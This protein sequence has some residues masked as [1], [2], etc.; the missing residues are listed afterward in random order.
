VVQE[1]LEEDWSP[2]QIAVWLKRTYAGEP[3]MRVSHKTI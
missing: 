1:R 3:S 2:E